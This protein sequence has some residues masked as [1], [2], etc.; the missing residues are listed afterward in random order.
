MSDIE[1]AF[2]AIKAKGKPY[3]DL[4]RYY[5]GSA[6]L[7]YSTERLARAFGK[8]FVYFAENWA[9][10]IINAVL[11]RLVLKGFDIGSNSINSKMDDLFNRYNINLDAQDVHESLQVTGEAFL[12]VDMVNGETD[13]YF[14]D[15]RMCEMFYDP[16]RP[17][18][19]AFAAKE[20]VTSDG[21]FI[22]LYYK[23]RTEKWFS[24]RAQTGKSFKLLESTRN[25]LGIIPVFHFRNSRRITKGELDPS[26]I[27]TLDAINKLFSDLMV[28]AEYETFKIKVFIS[29]VDPGDIKIGPDM[30]LW[31]P[32][33]E[34]A[35]GQDTSVTELGG[36][37]LET[38]LK[39]INDLANTLAITTRTPKHY[40]FNEGQSPSG[41]ALLTME[42]PLVKKVMKK[43]EAYDPTWKEFIAYV[44]LLNGVTVDPNDISTVWE[45]VESIQPLTEAQIIKT[46]KEAG[47]P[48]ITSARRAGWAEDEIAQLEA[49][50]AKEGQTKQQ[51]LA[52]SL[53]NFNRG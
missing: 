53:M 25:E 24:E 22:N 37:S 8:S 11:D 46:E 26:I 31:L 34:N 9:S 36:S 4:Y 2:D 7:K 48:T 13:I 45:P 16:D 10:V 6:P 27:S 43:Q 29:Q 30:K 1:L 42:S 41:E 33:N 40:F 28:A 44:L 3:T 17:K 49:D 20:W 52:S 23:D 50:I 47:I 12:I 51:N 18:L 38:F 14:N 32:A 19:K 5:D 21:T 35:T 39:P 15:P